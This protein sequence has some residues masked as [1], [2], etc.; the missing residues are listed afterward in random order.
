VGATSAR[1]ANPGGGSSSGGEEE[2]TRKERTT[3]RWNEMLQELRVAQTGV[4]VLTGFLLTVPFSQR[5]PDLDSVQRTAYLVVVSASI[6]AAG[7]LIAP[8]AFHRVLF[9]RNEKEWLVEAANLSARAGLTALGV[10]MSGVMF[11]VFDVVLG[12][13]A[14]VI[15][16]SATVV[17]LAVLWLVIP[18]VGAEVDSDDGLRR[19]N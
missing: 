17:L 2:E 19:K 6:L 7:L 3:R 16:T 8:V 10:T 13:T 4:Q 12:R 15:T 1:Q 9:G 11:L 14:S 5:F 18:L